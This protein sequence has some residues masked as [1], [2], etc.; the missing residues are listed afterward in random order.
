[1]INKESTNRNFLS[2]FWDLASDD[3]TRRSTAINLIMTHIESVTKELKHN[4]NCPDKD[5]AINRLVRGLTSSRESARQGFAVCLCELLRI[6]Q[7][8]DLQTIMNTIDETTKITGSF[9]GAEERDLIFGRLFGYIAIVRSGRLQDEI[10][11]NEKVLDVL[12][13][14]YNSKPWIHEAVIESILAFFEIIPMSKNTTQLI[15]KLSILFEENILTNDMSIDQLC[16]AIGLRNF[17][18]TIESGFPT[19]DSMP[20]LTED[21]IVTVDLIRALTG[22]LIGACSGFPKIHQIWYY[23]I[24]NIFN[25]KEDKFSSNNPKRLPNMSTTQEELLSILVHFIDENLLTASHEK[26]SVALHIVPELLA[27]SPAEIVPVAVS[28]A[29]VKCLISCRLIKKHTLHILADKAIK[30]LVSAVADNTQARL[31]LASILVQHGGSEFDAV[32]GTRAVSDLLEG[33]DGNSVATHVLFLCGVLGSRL[34]VTEDSSGVSGMEVEDKGDDDLVKEE[35]EEEE[36]DELL[37]ESAEE[38]RY[39]A[40]VATVDALWAAVRNTRLQNRGR[41]VAIALAA[42]IRVACFGAGTTAFPITQSSTGTDSKKLKKLKKDKKGVVNDPL[43]AKTDDDWSQL[44]EGV[45]EAIVLVE[46]GAPYSDAVVQAAG[47]R[48]LSILSD[49]GSITLAALDAPILPS[50]T[51]LQTDIGVTSEDGVVKMDI[52]DKLIITGSSDDTSAITSSN[53]KNKNSPIL[54]T[55][56]TDGLNIINVALTIASVISTSKVPYLVEMTMINED[57]EDM[58]EQQKESE[59]EAKNTLLTIRSINKLLHQLIIS[60]QQQS[61]KV[62]I[63]IPLLYLASQSFFLIASTDAVGIEVLTGLLDAIPSMIDGGSST[64]KA[65]GEEDTETDSPQVVLLEASLALLSMPGDSVVK[66]VRDAVRK[67]WTALCATHTTIDKAIINR[68]CATVVGEEDEGDEDN[69]DEGENADKDVML[70][71]DAS[72]D[73]DVDG[74]SKGEEEEEEVILSETDAMKL[75]GEGE[76]DGEEDGPAHFDDADNA[77]VEMLRHKQA[78]RKAGQRDILRSELLHR[79]RASDILEILLGNCKDGGQILN[80]LLAFLRCI[81]K[82]QSSMVIQALAEG[83]ALENRIRSLLEAKVCRAKVHILDNDTDSLKELIGAPLELLMHLKSPNNVLRFQALSGFLVVT[84]LVLALKTSTSAIEA[85]QSLD[86]VINDA[87]DD[88]RTRKGCRIPLRLFDDLLTRFQDYTVTLLLQKLIDATKDSKTEYF[89]CESYRLLI[90]ILKRHKSLNSESKG[91]LDSVMGAIVTNTKQ[92]IENIAKAENDMKMSPKLCKI[93][94]QCAREVV[95]VLRSFSTLGEARYLGYTNSYLA[96]LSAL[97]LQKQTYVQMLSQILTPL[98]SIHTQLTKSVSL[99]TTIAI[100]NSTSE[101]KKGKKGVSSDSVTVSSDTNGTSTS[102]GLTVKKKKKVTAS[103]ADAVDSEVVK[104]V[105]DMSMN[106]S[107][108]ISIPLVNADAATSEANSSNDFVVPKK[109]K[110]K[111][112]K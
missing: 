95:S 67:V 74:D 16:L 76:E 38:A 27:R 58:N 89:K 106:N 110:Q 72:R 100:T 56:N 61:Y 77:L 6:F 40:G 31:A 14:L 24:D 92:D 19:I 1:M 78:S 71:G 12:L 46:Q 28:K 107:D 98:S 41:V 66:G 51:M 45:S 17:L 104:A 91:L 105:A 18:L 43:H 73:G 84:R 86:T 22:T 11:I 60:G 52:P 75:L 32:T 62:K 54:A 15:S 13:E 70:E 82:L 102:T 112:N 83:K 49:M 81:K 2:N 30:S 4:E 94:L 29:F 36:E 55:T 90:A 63:G 111:A 5:Y 64:S 48:L 101:K 53:K 20:F 33:L 79:T 69:E 88:C 87:F 47:N 3:F 97:V 37:A 10:V 8:I 34:E 23:L 68:V 50:T 65:A 26:R 96:T 9:K 57:E 103:A 80:V 42:L 39:I 85:R 21:P 93:V 108:I 99:E 109:K 7:D 35:E 44:P 25:I 59:E